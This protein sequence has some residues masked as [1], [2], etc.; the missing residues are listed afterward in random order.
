M[1]MFDAVEIIWFLYG[2]FILVEC[3]YQI[4]LK[5]DQFTLKKQIVHI[6][7]ETGPT[8]TPP[9]QLNSVNAAYS[10]RLLVPVTIIMRD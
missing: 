9:W 10:Y 6:T 7:L 3:V 5:A 4:T 2:I 1:A 8:K